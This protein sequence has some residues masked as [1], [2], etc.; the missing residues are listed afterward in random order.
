MKYIKIAILSV[1]F[2]YTS[3]TSLAQDT[4]FQAQKNII[5]SISPQYVFKNGM[6]FDIEYNLK[7]KKQWIGISPQ[8]YYSNNGGYF[9]NFFNYDYSYNEYNDLNSNGFDTLTGFGLEF[10]HKIFLLDR[11]KA[12]GFYFNYGVKFNYFDLK[13]STYSWETEIIDNLEYIEYLPTTQSHII[14]KLGFNLIIGRQFELSDYL[15]IDLYTGVGMR[16]SAHSK[17]VNVIKS[18]DN[19]IVDFGYSGSLLLLGVKIGVGL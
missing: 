17:D 5:A 15:Y 6:R 8:I 18:F 14:N 13:Y 11:N 1:F 7:N 10:Y 16:Y 9:D 3:I 2:I 12:A 4:I 19:S